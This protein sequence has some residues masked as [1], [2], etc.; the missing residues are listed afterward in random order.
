VA[1]DAKIFNT[2]EV[3][4]HFHCLVLFGFCHGCHRTRAKHPFPL[5][6]HTIVMRM[7]GNGRVHRFHG[8]HKIGVHVQPPMIKLRL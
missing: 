8:L 6:H 2:Y 3:A 1:Y 5:Q 4:V 7:A